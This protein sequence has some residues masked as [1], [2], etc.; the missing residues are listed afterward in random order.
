MFKLKFYTIL[1]IVLST[2]FT[3]FGQNTGIVKGKVVDSQT[4]EALIGVNMIIQGTN[5]GFSTDLDGHYEFK[6][7]PGS[8]SIMASY[9]G[10]KSLEKSFTIKAGE[11]TELDFQLQ[12]SAISLG[13]ELVVL[14]SRTI[15]SI[16]AT[17][18]P[19]DIITAKDIEEAGHTELNQVL[20]SLAPSF[21]AS[22]QT[23]SDGTD[24]VM[25]ASLRG[26]GPDQVLVL[27]NG[28]RRHSSALLNV[29][30][31]FGRGTVGVD[32]NAIPLAA[33][34]RIEILRDGAAAQYGS[35]A[36]AGVI[37]VV[38]KK[39]TNSLQ[40]NATAGLS[41]EGDGQ[42]VQTGVN[43]GFELGEGGFL[44]ISGNFIN[45]E[46][47]NRSGTWTGD[48]FPGISGEAATNA[49]LANRGLTR[50][51]F[52]MK[53]GQGEGT[54]G[55]VFF[56]SSVPLKGNA[57]FYTFGG[58][59]HRKGMATGF[60]RLPNSEARVVPSLYPN[61]FLPEIHTEIFD[62]SFAGGVKGSFNGWDVD[63]SV[64]HGGNSFQFNIENTNNASMGAA[65]PISFD[66]GQLRFS[67]T[68]GNLDITRLIDTKGALKTLTFAFGSEFRVENY[69][70]VAGEDASWML[71]N[72]GSIPGVDFDTTSSGAPK[73]AGSQVFPGF[74]PSNE[75]DRY[76]N[77][78]AVYT[79]LESVFSD[80]FLV[81]LGLRF[82]NY[83]D[84]GQTLIGKL[85]TRYEITDKIALRGAASTGFRAPS[86]HQAWFNNV[87]TQFVID[88]AT[89]ELT[90]SQVMTAH[91]KS[92]VAKAFGIPDLEE[93]KSV[94][95]SAGFT[96]RPM[97]GLSVSA[98]FYS[99]SIN[100]RIVL[101][102]R[103]SDSDPIVAQI[104]APFA[105]SGVSKA[106]FFSNAVDTRTK[107]FDL[108][109]SYSTLVGN[110]SLSI[111]AV[112]NITNTEVV[113]INIPQSVADKFAGGDLK[114]VESTI[115]NREERNRLEDAL[116]RQ[117]GSITATYSLNKVSFTVRGNYYGSIE[118]KPTNIANDETFGAKVLL[119]L[120][121][122]YELFEGLKLTLGANNAL[123]TFPD[124]HQK[125]ANRSGERFIYSRRVTQFG[126]LGGFYY[127]G[128]R[129]NL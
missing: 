27:V 84:F 67:Q 55:M 24:H 69:Q 70:I 107:G 109:V 36:I 126:T 41:G 95:F 33:I 117:K 72:G 108:S 115:F 129:L 34:E 110:G 9:I 58:V 64:T 124:E 26:L 8:Y 49:E 104:L 89:G 121:A 114:A 39:Q 88:P 40:V 10:Y 78:I 30:G 71:G 82:E 48:I 63:L 29:N 74:Q 99:I 127:G 12:P 122:S 60:F 56:N 123:N 73:A 111:T 120:E 94:N 106:Q 19:V 59:S 5:N 3:I 2:S 1:F 21:N 102:S 31:T 81:D 98:D 80:K 20:R 28:K 100:D 15:R 75:V 35:D 92:A 125:A 37:N 17:P 51:D 50:D 97:D 66:A 112:G 23:I 105:N 43:Y 83:N 13:Q 113:N 76:R 42:K 25:P 4:Q 53:T 57:E 65:S 16:T 11:A 119:D 6:L 103:F 118:Y 86:L 32:F 93:E 85:A 62:L 44:N 7:S 18:V 116:P 90:P 54:S 101:T 46:R 52:S 61:G 22:Q 87:S 47:T 38:L 45:K 68:S 96:F 14:G 79:G 77:S 91:N 128:F